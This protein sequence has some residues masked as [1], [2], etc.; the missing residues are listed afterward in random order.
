MLTRSRTA[1]GT[2]VYARARSGGQATTAQ[3]VLAPLCILAAGAAFA[4]EVIV[5]TDATTFGALAVI[6]VLA[7]SMLRSRPL[8][9]VVAAFSMLLQAWGVAAGVVSRDEAGMQISVYL[10]VLVVTMLHQARSPIAALPQRRAEPEPE[11]RRPVALPAPVIHVTGLEVMQPMLAA[12]DRAL[13]VEVTGRL[14]RRERDVVE[15]AVQG[16]TARQIGSLLFIGDRTVETHLA[17]AYGKL[18]VRSKMELIHIVA[19]TRSADPTDLRTRTEAGGRL[20]A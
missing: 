16:L 1:A 6:P 4:A 18:G 2:R 20:T 14:T 12:D 5:G 3:Q 7:A 13:P 19:A 10:L 8:T 11:L 15:L 17:N 9:L